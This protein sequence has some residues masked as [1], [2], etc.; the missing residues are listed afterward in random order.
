[1][2][3]NRIDSWMSAARALFGSGEAEETNANQAS[4]QTSAPLSE[5]WLAPVFANMSAVKSP[6][7]TENTATTTRLAPAPVAASSSQQ[8]DEGTEIPF[9]VKMPASHDAR[10]IRN[11]ILREHF[12]YTDEDIAALDAQGSNVFYIQDL[13][14]PGSEAKREYVKQWGVDQSG[15]V[16]IPVNSKMVEQ[17][18]RFRAQRMVGS[19]VANIS[20]PALREQ[21]ANNLF[22]VLTKT[23]DERAGAAAKLNELAQSSSPDASRVL[24]ATRTIANQPEGRE[25]PDLR[26][27][28]ASMNTRRFQAT[29]GPFTDEYIAARKAEIQGDVMAA[30]NLAEGRDA[31][32]GQTRTGVTV[33]RNEAARI[34]REAARI[35]AENGDTAQAQVR[36]RIARFYEVDE[37]ERTQAGTLPGS[38]ID[39]WKRP[40]N[41]MNMVVP[42]TREEQELRE[43]QAREG[44]IEGPEPDMTHDPNELARNETSAEKVKVRNVWRKRQGRMQ[45][46]QEYDYSNYPVNERGIRNGEAVGGAVILFNEVMEY[47]RIWRSAGEAAQRL[48]EMDR[49]ERRAR[50]STHYYVPPKPEDLPR[51]RADMERQ[52]GA[53]ANPQARQVVNEVMRQTEEASHAYWGR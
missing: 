24:E 45:Q 29:Y 44:E 16:T 2:S 5:D 9:T 35:F 12:H 20:D 10:E 25:N 53:S 33:D 1:M 27:A 37:Q 21:V 23:G 36:E 47:A 14:H 30:V 19:A 4:T 32:T 52:F 26:L 38:M 51:L 46:V 13:A 3:S 11:E 34:N 43:A 50:E 15:N 6:A 41:G 28:L 17:L 48:A 22:D 31:V 18:R 40:T 42:V 49:L 39:R 8:T 7:L